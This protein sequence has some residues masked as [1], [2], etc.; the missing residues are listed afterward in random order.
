[1]RASAG[2]QFRPK[3]RHGFGLPRSHRGLRPRRHGRLRA[4]HPNEPG[5]RRCR[6]RVRPTPAA[7]HSRGGWAR[8]TDEG[9]LGGGVCAR[10]RPELLDRRARARERVLAAGSDYGRRDAQLF[11]EEPVCG[12]DVLEP[13]EEC[14]L[15]SPIESDCCSPSCTIEPAGTVCLPACGACD[16]EDVC[17]GASPLCPHRYQP[18]TTLCRP[19]AGPCGI[20]GPT[21]T[22]CGRR[23]SLPATG[24]SC[25]RRSLR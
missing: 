8:S 9:R 5:R 3:S 25:T 12:N 6:D 15:E 20:A 24:P 13:G 1:M 17:T 2:W 19:A 18:S 10:G 11:T 16:V 4:A 14:D 22:N 7:A 21:R 23:G